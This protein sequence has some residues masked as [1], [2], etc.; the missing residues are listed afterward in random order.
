[1]VETEGHMQ[2]GDGRSA[3]VMEL[4]SEL[5]R[6]VALRLLGLGWKVAGFSSDPE[7]LA[8]LAFEGAE[9]FVGFRHGLAG[10]PR[11][12]HML[13]KL[14]AEL[15]SA[16]LLVNNLRDRAGD[17][18]TCAW[19]ARDELVEVV[20]S[21]LAK[22]SAPMLINL[23]SLRAAHEAPSPFRGDFVRMAEAL[24]R[25]LAPHGVRVANL[26]SHSLERPSVDELTAAIEWLLQC[27]KTVHVGELAVTGRRASAPKTHLRLLPSLHAEDFDSRAGERRREPAG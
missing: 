10:A 27:P 18:P 7:V 22:S 23:G 26:G 15:S 1:M 5:G 25:R 4:S 21:I 24:E 6:A 20:L 3:I 19:S 11:R 17:E 14:R 9:R 8:E 13:S 2:V 16:Q 12:A